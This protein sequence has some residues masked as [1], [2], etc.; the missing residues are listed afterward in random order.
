MTAPT[1][2]TTLQRHATDLLAVLQDMG[3]RHSNPVLEV[4]PERNRI[5]IEQKYPDP[6]LQFAANQ[7]R[8]FYHVHQP[9]LHPDEHGHFHVFTR[10]EDA[11]DRWGHVAALIMDGMGQ[12]RQWCAMNHWVTGGEWLTAETLAKKLQ[13]LPQ[14]VAEAPVGEWLRCM[15]AIYKGELLSLVQQRD[16]ILLQQNQCITN[17]RSIYS[18]ATITVD[19]ISKFPF[20]K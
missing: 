1:P 10:M 17:N 13:Q 20:D 5:V 18:L 3:N 15:L 6:P 2:V 7:W 16:R 9:K 11:S 14:T 12:P 8:A 4:L 19:L